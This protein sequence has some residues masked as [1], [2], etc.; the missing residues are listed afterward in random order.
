MA[1][2][3]GWTCCVVSPV[4]SILGCWGAAREKR[5]L[6]EKRS[7]ETQP[8]RRRWTLRN[9]MLSRVQHT[10][11]TNHTPASL[12]RPQLLISPPAP[13]QL[14]SPSHRFRHAVPPASRRRR[15]PRPRGPVVAAVDAPVGRAER[16]VDAE[17][18]HVPAHERRRHGGGGDVHRWPDSAAAP[19]PAPIALATMTA[20]LRTC[21]SIHNNRFWCT[22]CS[23]CFAPCCQG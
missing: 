8:E 16:S 9:P 17:R 12:T 22:G 6:F 18:P 19:S 20:P 1:T 15:G 11:N 10:F 5:Y 21:G 7:T 4:I 13:T 2:T 14:S 3:R 23:C